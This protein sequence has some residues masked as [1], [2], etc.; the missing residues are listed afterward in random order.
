M[1]GD[2]LLLL[3]LKLK[4]KGGVQKGQLVVEV[5]VGF[6][7]LRLRLCREKNSGNYRLNSS[8]PGIKNCHKK[9]FFI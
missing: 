4:K 6:L 8:T 3:L 1:G 7:F 9:H 5:L 2:L